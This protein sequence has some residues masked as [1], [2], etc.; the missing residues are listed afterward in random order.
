[1]SVTLD[2]ALQTTAGNRCPP[3]PLSLRSS[4]AAE[5]ARQ[6]TCCLVAVFDSGIR[7]YGVYRRLADGTREMKGVFVPGRS[8]HGRRACVRYAAYE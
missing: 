6:G 1:V 2:P 7:G 4:A 3:V 8:P 5:S